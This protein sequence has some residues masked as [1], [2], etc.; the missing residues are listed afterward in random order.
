MGGESRKRE[1]EKGGL[2]AQRGAA[3]RSGCLGLNLE[4]LEVGGWR[5]T[6]QA[7]RQSF[8]QLSRKRGK[9]ANN[10]GSDAMESAQSGK[11]VGAFNL[12]KV[13]ILPQ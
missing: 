11:A 1:K 3:A 4:L 8:S 9:L 2:S 10:D 13:V 6:L 5:L 12:L 7:M